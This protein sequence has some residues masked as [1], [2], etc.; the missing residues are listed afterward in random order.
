[1]VAA[2]FPI[3]SPNNN[4]CIFTIK[5]AKFKISNNMHEFRKKASTFDVAYASLRKG[6]GWVAS[7]DMDIGKLG[8]GCRSK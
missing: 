4:D 1:M 2:T 5:K 8:G 7:T 6:L 3:N